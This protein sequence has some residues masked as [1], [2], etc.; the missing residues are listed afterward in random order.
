MS[1]HTNGP[2]LL[3]A[4]RASGPGMALIALIGALLLM[5]YAVSGPALAQESPSPSVDP[6]ASPAATDMASPDTTASPR[7]LPDTA[8]APTDPGANGTLGLAIALAA[9]GAAGV[10]LLVMRPLARRM[11]DDDRAG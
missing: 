3:A 1:Q 8:A 7:A 5:M 4:R 2:V 6:A 9:I 11:Q 10:M